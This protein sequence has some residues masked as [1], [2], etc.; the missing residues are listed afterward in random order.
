MKTPNFTRVC[1]HCQQEFALPR[2]TNESHGICRRHFERELL[3][4]GFSAGQISASLAR[5]STA[6]F[7]PDLAEQLEAA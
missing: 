1:A 5:K 4:A 6:S 7:C 2:G 3:A